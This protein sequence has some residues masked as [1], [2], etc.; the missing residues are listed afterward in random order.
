MQAA[1]SA[2]KIKTLRMEAARPSYFSAR[3][4]GRWLRAD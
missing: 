3:M 1:A 2:I 4:A